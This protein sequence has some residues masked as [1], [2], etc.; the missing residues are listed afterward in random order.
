MTFI[1]FDAV[2]HW[3]PKFIT[4]TELTC[5]YIRMILLK[6]PCNIERTRIFMGKCTEHATV[7]VKYKM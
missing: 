2:Q 5:S 4:K 6:Y 7:K 1:S 3:R